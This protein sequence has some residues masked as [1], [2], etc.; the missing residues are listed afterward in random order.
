MAGLGG[1]NIFKDESSKIFLINNAPKPPTKTSFQDGLA[2]VERFKDALEARNLNEARGFWDKNPN[3]AE[4]F[5]AEGFCTI[6][7]PLH[8]SEGGL[9]GSMVEVAEWLEKVL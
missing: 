4:V 8:V 5:A 7:D 1:I 2:S 6:P 9:V 3:Q